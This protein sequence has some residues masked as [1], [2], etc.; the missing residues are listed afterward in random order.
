LAAALAGVLVAQQFAV[1]I[2]ATALYFHLLIAL[3]VI[4][5]WSPWMS[6]E[7]EKD[8]AR[9]WVWIPSAVVAL[10]LTGVAVQVV[11][12]DH[13]FAVVQQRI[14][15][16]DIAG[17][18][19]AYRTVLR[20]QPLGANSDLNYSRA[21]QQAAARAP[22]LPKRAEA[23]QQALE[24]AIRAVGSAED[25]QNAWYNLAALL[26]QENDAQGTERALRNAIAWAPNWFK[27]HWALAR[28]L[29]I[30]GYPAEALAEARMAV[31]RDGGHDPEVAQTLQQL[32]FSKAVH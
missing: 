4:V 1:F 3:L 6:A 31:D 28:L 2:V 22:I 26:A 12:A 20:W 27:P 29:A 11:V 32:Q 23:G 24:A 16:G 8:S 5:A 9:R 17:A 25:R 7:V 15:A 13:A 18:S 14:A 10:L 21:M 30:S 19:E